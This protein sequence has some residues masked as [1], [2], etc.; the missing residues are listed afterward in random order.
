M[1]RKKAYCVDIFSGIPP[2]FLSGITHTKK[3]SPYGVYFTATVYGRNSRD[4]LLI[5]C[6]QRS[7]KTRWYEKQWERSSDYRKNFFQLNHGPYFCVYCG[8]RL[9]KEYMQ[10]DH[11]V[12]VSQVKKSRYAR[13]LL[14]IRNIK[15]VND[16]RNL[17][18]SCRKCNMKKGDSIGLWYIRGMLGKK[19]GHKKIKQ[20]EIL[21]FLLVILIFTFSCL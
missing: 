15:N 14:K 3:A 6:R 21:A 4:T 11:I 2:D 19:Y 12:P 8:R 20:A 1:P 17:V 13:F 18:P 9:K 7:I 10:I 16:E 5:K